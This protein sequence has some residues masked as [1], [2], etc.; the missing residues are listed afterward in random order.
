[1]KHKTK[2]APLT[3]MADA[4]RGPVQWRQLVDWLREDGVITAVEADRTIARCSQAES[5]QP[6]LV[7]LAAVGMQRASD[8]QAMDVEELTQHLA[9]RAGLPYLRIDPLRVDAGKVSDTMSATYAERHKVLPV[10]VT[11]AEV[12]VATSEPFIDDWVA[13]VERQSRRSVRR[14]VANPAEIKRFTAE[15]FALAKS[16]RAAIKS[17][18]AAGATS[19]EQLVELGKTGRQLDANDQGV[20]QVV[21]WLWQYAFDQRASDIHLEP[22]RDQGVI[23]FRIDGVLHPVYQ[24]PP[25]VMNAITARVK[26]LGR[27]DVVEKRRPQDGRIKTRNPRGDEIEMRLST[28]PTAFG[29]KLVMRIFDPDTAVKD[30]SALGF[31][32]HDAGRWEQLVSRPHG[33]ILVTGPTGS[34]K[35]TTLY[36]TLR[37]VATEEVNVSTIEDPIEKI[38]P[39]LNQTQV[40]PQ[41]DFSFAEGVR[42]LMRQD[43]DIIMIGEIRDLETA[44]MAVQAALTGHLV[45]STLHTNDA[46]SALTRLMELGVPAYL[47]NA[48]ILGVLAQRLVRTLCPQ[49]KQPDDGA[50]TEL[51]AEAVK[52][53]KIN[54]GNWRPYK[55]IGCVDCRMT[56]FRGRMGIYELL[57]VTEAFKGLVQHDV[58]PAPLRKQAVADGM[59]PL[60]LAGAMRAAEGLT[61]LPEVIAATPPLS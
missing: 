7:R 48:T 3:P 20:I 4:Y 30:L 21:D 49:C 18:G 60:R 59:R 9:R 39:A 22:R 37:R 56:G 24:V 23:R 52:P 32:P 12:V 13:E 58:G 53:W 25:G 26:L 55:P 16:V 27:M 5:A 47:L 31:T 8:G 61:T 44:E 34:G 1:M 40:Q 41:L 35:T 6:A 2:P 50:S 43:P 29:E 46:P 42:A 54:S 33:I 17:G 38:D 19:F 28:L 15:F 14:V 57:S 36:S 51:L 11:A 10:Q 45:F